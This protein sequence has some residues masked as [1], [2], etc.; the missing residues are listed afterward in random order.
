MILVDHRRGGEEKDK[1]T[2]KEFVDRINRLGVKAELT[3]LEY[4]DFAFEG[5]GP[6]GTIAIGIERKTLH[7]MLNCIDDARFAGHQKIG[8]K[9]MYQVNVLALEGHWKPHDPFGILME[10]FNGGVSWGYCRYRSQ[11]TMY[12]KLYRYLISVQLAGVLYSP[13]RDIPH[14]ALNVCE[15]YHYF[16]KRWTDHDSF[17][18]IHKIAIPQMNVKPPLVRKW[19]NDLEGIG[20]KLSELAARH[21]RT[22]IRLATAEETDWLRLPGIG[23]KTAT[24]VVKEIWGVKV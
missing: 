21:F 24:D 14:T 8:M 19:A 6:E 3:D 22:P 9:Q 13:S 23:V 20:T 15:Y 12:A 10:G 1:N 18:E 17:K 7:D 4:G 11:R 5:N 2:P 16:Q